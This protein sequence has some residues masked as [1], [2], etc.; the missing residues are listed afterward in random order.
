MKKEHYRRNKKNDG[1]LKVTA[2]I[3]AIVIFVCGMF[4][5]LNLW[6][7]HTGQF[8]DIDA[9]AQ[10]S[11]VFEYE[12]K[13]YDLNKNIE[14][15]LV[16]GL[17]K[18]NR[19]GDESYSN[20]KQADFLMLLVIDNEKEEVSALHINRDTIAKM[21]VLGVAG[22]KID[23]IEQQ[24]ALAHTYGNGK[25]VSCRNTLEAVSNM[26]LNIDIDHYV[27]VTMDAVSIYNDLVGGVNVTV[28]DDFGGI[29]DSLVKDEEVTLYGEHALNYVRTRYGLEDSSNNNRMERQH[30]YI[31]ALYDKTRECIDGD[32]EFIV[33]A[34]AK[35]STY[36]VSDCSGNRLQ[37]IAEKIANYEFVGIKEIEGETVKGD[38]YIEFYPDAESVKET[39]VELF[40][41]PQN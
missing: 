37:T 24:I 23:K 11:S 35:L 36:L 29:D 16:L 28:L 4:F 1:I 38:K 15:I 27:S 6:E 30:Q 8:N 26:L 21:S 25:E 34:A 22:D 20:D 7:K 32:D 3:L 33:N 19:S 39:V 13:T 2:V 18:F 10:L 5:A 9:S 31:Q 12:G 41:T 17:D 14:T 40:Y